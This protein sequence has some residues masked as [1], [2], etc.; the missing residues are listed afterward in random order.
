MDLNAIF[1]NPDEKPLDH[2]PSDGGFCGI[3]RTIACIGDSLA[4]GEFEA[5]DDEGRKSYHDM[6]EYSWG[7]NLA[8]IVG[9]KAYNFSR[10]GMSAAEYCNSFADANDLWNPDKA[11]QAYIIALGVNDVINSKQEVGST[12]DIDLNDWRNNAKTFSG[13]YGQIIQRYREIQPQARFFLMTMPNDRRADDPDVGADERGDRHA[14]ALYQMAEFFPHTYVIDLR[15]YAPR[16]D[17]SFREK[18]YL[19]GHLNPAGYILT[20]QMVASYIDYIIRHNM[21]DFI[22]TGFIGT[23]YY[24]ERFD[25]K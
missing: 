1:N 12:A 21:N 6:F 25:R 13:Y 19:F 17:E 16:Y 18:F 7:Q 9:C 20:A 10:G 23:P 4:S 15:K 5:V 3:F 14:E 2:F 11:A 24:M 22:Q 8:R